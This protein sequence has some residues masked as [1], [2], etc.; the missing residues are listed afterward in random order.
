MTQR[1]GNV[2]IIEEEPE[3]ECELC[4]TMA[5]TRPYGP[6][7]CRVCFECAMKDEEVTKRNFAKFLDGESAE[8]LN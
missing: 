6:G 2:V 8:K 7:G 4:H 3:M 1:I 5:E